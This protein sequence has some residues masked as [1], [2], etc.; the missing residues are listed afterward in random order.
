[1]ILGRKSTQELRYAKAKS[2]ASEFSVPSSSL[3]PA[4]DTCDD[5]HYS[6]IL[7][8]SSYIEDRIVGGTGEE[9]LSDLEKVASFYDAVSSDKRNIFFD[10]GYWTLAM[11]SYCLL[12]NYGSAKVAAGKIS[13]PNFYGDAA[14]GI[15]GLV[16]YLL[17]EGSPVP[18]EY[19]CL[20]KYLSGETISEDEIVR[21][22]QER[23]IDSCPED[24]FFS[25]VAYVITADTLNNSSRKLLPLFSSTTEA[26]WA[27]YFSKPDSCKILWQAQRKIGA[28]G[29]FSGSSVFVQLP[30]GTGK[31]KSLDL[32]IRS[33]IV[34]N[35]CRTAIVVAPL[36]ALCTEIARDL[37]SSLG[38]LA[39]VK[40]TSDVF[41]LDPWLLES[42]QKSRVLV[43]TPE[44]LN[45][46]IHHE[47]SLLDTVDLFVFDEAHL[48]DSSSRGPGYELLLSEIFKKKPASQIVLISAVVSNPEQIAEW[49]FGK[50]GRIVRSGS[51]QTTEKALGIVSKDGRTIDFVEPGNISDKNYFF[52]INIQ[53]QQLSLQPGERKIRLFPDLKTKSADRGRDLSLFYAN[54]L[55][56]NGA[57]ALYFPQ[58]RSIWPFCSHLGDLVARGCS[59]PNVSQAIDSEERKKMERLVALH[60]GTDCA[61]I[62]GVRA[63]V[64][65]HYGDLQGSIRLAVEHILENG[66]GRCIACTSTLAQGVNLPI[67]YLIVTGVRSGREQPKTRDF[68]NLIGRTA[69]SGKYSEGSVLVVDDTSSAKKQR[70]Y[71]NLADETETESCDSAIFNLLADCSSGQHVIPG[72]E[73]VSVIL[74]HILDPNLEQKLA[75][76]LAK[77]INIDIDEA[78]FDAEKRIT[79]LEAIESYVSS[80]ME[81]EPSGIDVMEICVATYAYSISDDDQKEQLEKLFNAIK[82]A[83]EDNRKH[84]AIALCS[85]T[86]I[87]IR[88][89]MLIRSWL[90][91]NDGQA[92]FENACADLLSLLELFVRVE[93]NAVSPFNAD[94]LAL[95]VGDWLSGRNVS[96]V[97]THVSSEFVLGNRTD[98][99]TIEGLLSSGIK[100]SLSHFISCVLD[101]CES[102]E[103]G[104]ESKNR[105]VLSALQKKI[106]YGVDNMRAVTFCEECLD[107]R[108]IAKGVISI[109]GANGESD[110]TV[111]KQEIRSCSSEMNK[112]LSTL[113][114]YCM[115]R[116]LHW[117]G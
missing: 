21:E 97:Y 5:L 116:I 86:R 93:P 57:A 68:T 1:M 37:D 83:L 72:K 88:K 51:I 54:M 32:L 95:I 36:R 61:L 101:V 25:R 17:V 117:A 108:M 60:Y 105:E 96:E 23:I 65:P 26:D 44:K 106:K 77:S 2:K 62:S 10:D 82:E 48:L 29:A 79:S 110:A 38:S 3:S 91:S 28:E 114:T 19:S 99:R 14:A 64:L 27:D 20:G 30:T 18:P 71:S 69:R 70:L 53:Q 63:G 43:S 31:T 9:Y 33:R 90:L 73:I 74:Q 111:I 16:R 50:T 39:E 22:A 67:K 55:L 7:V 52:K 42:S 102:P 98:A 6:S 112:L 8:I 49:A 4:L 84:S 115:E 66:K 46:A 80:A 81:S 94:Q 103:A 34:S 40:Q 89:T 47:G 13:N 56:P 113:P 75:S 59:I 45:F 35:S 107:D 85:K 109:I 41:E 78:A 15:V 11:C 76:A 24:Y 100:Y 87:G 58:K 12:E 92:F 104:I